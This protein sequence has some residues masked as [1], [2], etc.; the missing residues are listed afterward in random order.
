MTDDKDA[1]IVLVYCKK[2]ESNQDSRQKCGRARRLQNS[3]LIDGELS[4]TAWLGCRHGGSRGSQEI[5]NLVNFGA[6]FLGRKNLLQIVRCLFIV[7]Y[8]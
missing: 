6:K 7:E 5:L 2:K 4:V 3:V 8:M 1:L